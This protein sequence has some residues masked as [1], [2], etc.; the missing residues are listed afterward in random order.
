VTLGAAGGSGVVIIRYP[1][2]IQLS[3]APGLVFDT[4]TVGSDRVTTFTAGTGTIQLLEAPQNFQL[5]QSVVLGSDAS[6]VTFSNVASTYAANYK[7]LQIR[8]T[9]RRNASGSVGNV[10]RFNGDTGSNYTRHGI[11]GNGTSV[12][13]FGVGSDTSMFVGS[14]YGSGAAAGAFVGG[15]IDILDSFST[16]KFKTV[17][18]FSGRP[19]EDVAL[20]SGLWRNTSTINTILIYPDVG[21]TAFVAGSRFSLYGI[22]SS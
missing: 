8:Y 3:V 20:H 11:G 13:A 5:L 16:S 15:I 21:G 14:S 7:H 6:S 22:R 10:L 2:N 9:V 19:P 1:S 18:T 4:N 17:K 12:Y